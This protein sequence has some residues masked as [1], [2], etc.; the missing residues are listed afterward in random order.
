MPTTPDDL[1]L[2]WVSYLSN[3]YTQPKRP[4]TMPLDQVQEEERSESS[5]VEL[6]MPPSPTSMSENEPVPS[7]EPTDSWEDSNDGEEETETRVQSKSSSSS[8]SQKLDAFLIF[9][10]EW[11]SSSLR[12]DQGLKI[13]QWSFWAA[14]RLTAPGPPV[15]GFRGNFNR[16]HLHPELSPALRKMYADMSLVRYCLRLYGL[17]SSIEAIRSGSWSAG[18]DDPLIHKLGKI[19]AWSM[20][21]YYPLE[22]VAFTGFVVPKLSRHFADENRWSAVSC[23]FWTTYI[24]C[25][26]ASSVLKLKELTKRREQIA[27]E[28]QS[29]DITNDEVRQSD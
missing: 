28:A 15:P 4:P 25:D 24:V 6:K 11:S 8:L 27:R 18:W 26:F 2:V 23:R 9:W 17:P 13:P 14:S 20:A 3:E 29:G 22:H 12:V 21:L 19:M 7:L 16:R 10:N 1:T 5:T